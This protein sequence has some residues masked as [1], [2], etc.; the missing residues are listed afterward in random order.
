MPSVF[1]KVRRLNR[2]AVAMGFQ[3]LTAQEIEQVLMKAEEGVKVPRGLREE[4]LAA[5]EDV[6]RDALARARRPITEALGGVI[7]DS[8]RPN[9]QP[10][11]PGI[12]GQRPDR[13][14][15]EVF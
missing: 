12:P 13:P 8:M 7:A 14:V 10:G 4:G 2:M 11:I 9:A 3:P 1:D 6:I 15:S 5:H